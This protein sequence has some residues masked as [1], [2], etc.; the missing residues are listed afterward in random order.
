[1]GKGSCVFCKIAAKAIPSKTIFEDEEIIAFEDIKP[2]A[3]VH[4]IV[5]PKRHIEKASDL[6]QADIGIIGR[7]ILVAKE[8]GKKKDA[9]D[10]GFRIV[11]N[12]GRDAGQEVFHLHAHLLAGRKFTWPPG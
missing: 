7:L 6:T 9:R 3:P 8:I 10:S 2:Q 12:C 5:I 4:I 11:I 1:M